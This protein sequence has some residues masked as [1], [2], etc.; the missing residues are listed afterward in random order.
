MIP[1]WMPT[2]PRTPETTMEWLIAHAI[3]IQYDYYWKQ[4]RR[5]LE[6]LE[7]SIYS[8]HWDNI[9]CMSNSELALSLACHYNA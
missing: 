3:D 7:H 2:Q 4:P 1:D 9:G 8:T 6:N 5:D